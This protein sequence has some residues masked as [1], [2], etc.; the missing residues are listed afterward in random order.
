MIIITAYYLN[1]RI[2]YYAKII[3]FKKHNFR[4]A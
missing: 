4:T 3:I 2:A 1:N